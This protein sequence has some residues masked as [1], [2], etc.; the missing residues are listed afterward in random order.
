MKFLSLWLLGLLVIPSIS[1]WSL[2]DA[3]VE[4]TSNYLNFVNE[5]VATYL[6]NN[7][8]T[9]LNA[10]NTNFEW[11]LKRWHVAILLKRLF[12]DYKKIAPMEWSRMCQFKDLG[13]L[14]V[15]DQNELIEACEFG[16]MQGSNS[17]FYPDDIMI[18]EHVFIVLARLVTRDSTID[19]IDK[20]LP[21]L[22]ENRL[23]NTSSKPLGKY[24]VKRWDLYDHIMDIL[25]RVY[26]DKQIIEIYSKW[27][28][29]YP[30]IN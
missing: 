11:E 5:S 9:K 15:S 8:I 21:P 29:L 23:A 20:A 7:K 2:S 22:I 26:K 17:M 30:D 13:S 19:T 24:N 1:F 28:E 25:Y 18:R 12:K 10:A 14:A 4:R 16:I 3:Q 6:Y 27:R